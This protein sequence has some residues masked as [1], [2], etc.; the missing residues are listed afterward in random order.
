VIDV[1]SGGK[2][3]AYQA[4]ALDATVE[5]DVYVAYCEM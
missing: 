2:K 4:S 1:S 3:L 5:V